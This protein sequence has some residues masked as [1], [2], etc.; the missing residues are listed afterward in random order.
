[1]TAKR[2]FTSFDYDNDND[3][4]NALVGQAKY[5]NSPFEIID[6]SVRR[7]LHG[8]WEKQVRSRIRKTDLVIVM[9]GEHTHT[10]EGVAI[11]LKIAQEEGIKY[12]L[13]RGHK[14]RVCTKPTTARSND[15]MYEWTWNNLRR[16]IQGKTFAE[17]LEELVS[18]PTTWLVVGGL[19]FL[20]WKT[21]AL[22]A[23]VRP[24]AP[25]RWLSAQQYDMW[26]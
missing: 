13:L 21:G 18:S 12:F 16:L 17:A 22:E 5:P 8:D 23:L 15:V 6:Q 3:L 2:A 4:R 1:M 9:C 7:H 26:T 25:G 10:A 20:A 24:R 11:E 14:D 19:G